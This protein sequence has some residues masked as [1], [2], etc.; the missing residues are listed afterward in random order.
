MTPSSR[1]PNLIPALFLSV[2]LVIAGVSASVAGEGMAAALSD[3]V[4]HQAADDH[5]PC[6]HDQAGYGCCSA[7]HCVG[8]GLLAGGGVYFLSAPGADPVSHAGSALWSA[9]LYGLDRPPKA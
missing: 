9:G 1:W 4:S 2:M 6:P 8:P 5:G 3:T 7:A